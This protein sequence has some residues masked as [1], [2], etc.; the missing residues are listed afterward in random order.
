MENT[1]CY[2]PSVK[3][4]TH[5]YK[6][7]LHV[8]LF[9]H[10]VSAGSKVFVDLFESAMEARA[11]W[12]AWWAIAN[13]ARPELV[14]R[15]NRFPDFFLATERAHFN[16]I[17]VNLA[18]LFDRRRDVSNLEKYL[19]LAGNLY[20]PSET[21]EIGQRIEKHQVTIN[22]VIA[23]RNNV[24][25]HKNAGMTEKQVFKSAELKPRMIGTLVE[26]IVSIFNYFAE[27][28]GLSNR[29]FVSERVAE[30]TL[31]VI[32]SIRT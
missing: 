26:E 28:E 20:S 4:N 12:Q 1:L 15:M 10:M 2:A 16:C 32:K 31:G 19:K 6:C 22:G 17:F 18:H 24:I 29:I 11:H 14:P 3:I 5:L 25:A 21:Q 23:V 13:Q 30:A 8:R 27:R 9:A 7:I